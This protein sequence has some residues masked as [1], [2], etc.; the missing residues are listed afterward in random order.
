VPGLRHTNSQNF[1][2]VEILRRYGVI[3]KEFAK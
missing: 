2:P 1:L 3:K